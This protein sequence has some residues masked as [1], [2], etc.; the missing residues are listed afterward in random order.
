MQNLFW[1]KF[2]EQCEKFGKAPTTVVTE[3]GFSPASVTQ[4][5]N[6]SRPRLQSV[7][8]VADYFGVSPEVL[9]ADKTSTFYKNLCYL[10]SKTNESP[11]AIA[12]ECGLTSA[13]VTGWIA[14]HTPRD[15]T[16]K[17]IAKHF[18]TTID[19]LLSE[20]MIEKDKTATPKDDGL[21]DECKELVRRFCEAD[22]NGRKFI[23]AA[24][25]AA[26]DN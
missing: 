26:S 22:E 5:K 1:D 12:L 9:G 13:A 18:D 16:L 7:Y 6:G 15:I 2:V 23:W 25:R 21:D 4:W 8:K 10:C 17:Q 14:G 20:D 24:V 19:A 11:N 3:L